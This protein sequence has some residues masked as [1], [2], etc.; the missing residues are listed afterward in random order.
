VSLQLLNTAKHPIRYSL[1]IGN[2][3][4][5]LTIAA[6]AVQTVRVQL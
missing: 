4:A 6:N 3:Y 1:Q 5:A 2:Q